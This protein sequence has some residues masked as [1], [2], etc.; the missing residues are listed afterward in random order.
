[1]PCRVGITTRPEERKAEWEREVVG[2]TNWRIVGEY[3]KREQAQEHENRYAA[4]TGC[5]ASHGGADAS[6][7]WYV[8]RFD[9]VRTC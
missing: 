3:T 5:Q 1:M 2:L 6:G 8:Y 4:Q 7:H 9:Y